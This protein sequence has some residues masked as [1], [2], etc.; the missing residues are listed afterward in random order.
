[1]KTALT[2]QDEDILFIQAKSVKQ[3]PRFDLERLQEKY[4]GEHFPTLN[5]PSDQYHI[6]PVR[7]PL[8]QK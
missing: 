3:L 6:E 4:G 8:A 2:R 1:M 5:Q 7:V